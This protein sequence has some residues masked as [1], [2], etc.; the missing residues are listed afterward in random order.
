MKLY[1]VA[2]GPGAGPN[3]TLRAKGA[4]DKCDCIV[5]YK[6]S[7]NLIEI[8]Y[9]NKT[10]VKTDLGKDLE[11]CHMALQKSVEG[12]VTALV[13][14]GD[15]AVYTTSSMLLDISKEY[16]NVEIELIPGV[17][18][19]VAGASL[20]GAPIS[21]DYVVLSLSDYNMTWEVIERR[22]MCAIDGGFV[23][24]IHSPV[25]P[26]RMD[27]LRKAIRIVLW[28]RRPETICA[29]VRGAGTWGERMS[30]LTLEELFGTEDIDTH[31]TIYIGNDQ[32]VIVNGKM[33][34]P[35]GY[36]AIEGLVHTER[37]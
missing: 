34:T 35:R 10:L 2:L 21:D 1:V 8:D 15:T 28:K 16:P 19:A 11:A 20:L 31:A 29:V 6:N 3:M 7:V 27:A 26:G 5:G 30:I 12:T 36:S 14:A 17:S 33:H 18:S 22:L 24:C 25:S 9:M 32:T 4:L 23:V 13:L 37:V